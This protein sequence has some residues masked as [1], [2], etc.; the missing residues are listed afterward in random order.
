MAAQT[1]APMTADELLVMP[2]NDYRYELVQGELR[3]MEFADRQHGLLLPHKSVAVSE[4]LSHELM[5][6]AKPVQPGPAS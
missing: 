1:V 6:W 5:A 3:Q 2:H 4:H